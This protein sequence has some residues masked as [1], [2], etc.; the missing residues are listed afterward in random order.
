[1]DNHVHFPP[2][3][4]YDIFRKREAIVL[5]RFGYLVPSFLIDKGAQSVRVSALHAD[6][7]KGESARQMVS[8]ILIAMKPLPR[9]VKDFQVFRNQKHIFQASGERAATY[10][11]HTLGGEPKNRF[12]SVVGGFINQLKPSSDVSGGSGDAKG[13]KKKEST[14]ETEYVLVDVPEF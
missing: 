7:E 8:K 5:A 2:A 12:L 4:N 14:P 10:R 1:L 6:K 11:L 3:E 9:A 13:K